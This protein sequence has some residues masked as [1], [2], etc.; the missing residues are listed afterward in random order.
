[1]APPHGTPSAGMISSLR[2]T[3]WDDLPGPGA[4]VSRRT[5]RLYRV[6]P[7][8]LAEG[9]GPVIPILGPNGEEIVTR[10]SEDAYEPVTNLRRLA[11][12]SS[13]APAF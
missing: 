4:Y 11:V 1:M 6:P 12:E 13:I 3:P 2:T 7:S 5:G 10:L 9:Y 8:S